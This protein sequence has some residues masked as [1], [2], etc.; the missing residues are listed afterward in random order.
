MGISTAVAAATYALGMLF[1][2]M[3]STSRRGR[4][5]GGDDQQERW[6]TG[7]FSWHS[8]MLLFVYKDT[9]FLPNMQEKSAVFF[10]GE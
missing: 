7:G 2:L 4:L 1:L 5:L 9:K 8:L 6:G 3:P 10:E